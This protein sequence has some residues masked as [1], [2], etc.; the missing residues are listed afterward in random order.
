MQW[1]HLVKILRHFFLEVLLLHSVLLEFFFFSHF[2]VW[3]LTLLILASLSHIVIFAASFVSRMKKSRQYEIYWGFLVLFYSFIIVFLEI[4]LYIGIKFNYLERI[5]NIWSLALLL[6]LSTYSESL[7]HPRA[8][9]NLCCIP[10]IYRCYLSWR[11]DM[12]FLDIR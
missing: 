9:R 4:Y 5:K 3:I 1:I 6:I 10:S 11:K 8:H 12:P 7:S 2:F